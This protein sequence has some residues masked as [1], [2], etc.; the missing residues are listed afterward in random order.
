MTPEAGRLPALTP[1]QRTLPA[2]LQRQADCF[3]EHTLLRL[4][5]QH[6]RHADAAKLAAAGAAALTQAGWR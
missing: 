3:G 5:D 1:A 2:M 6:W 4:G